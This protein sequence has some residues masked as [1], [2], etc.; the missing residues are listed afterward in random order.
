ML[1]ANGV[2]FSKSDQPVVLPRPDLEELGITYR[3][4][5]LLAI[6][7]DIYADSALIIDVIQ[8]RWG[9]IPTSTADKAYEQWGNAVFQEVLG[10]IPSAVMTPEFI[11]DR[12]PIFPLLTRPDFLSLRP[13]SLAGFKARLR[14]AEDGFLATSRGPFLTGDKISLADIHFIWPI[15]FAFHN[16]G[17]DREPGFGKEAFPKVWKLLDNLP[18]FSPKVLNADETR[19]LIHGALDAASGPKVVAKDDPTGFTA[20]TQVS[21]ESFE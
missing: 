12:E 6:G 10:T 21:V 14:E 8:S 9:K 18:S 15:K 4:I 7:K 1:A 2:D 20:G 5:P 3:R 17:V 19:S 11:K 13:S 16:L